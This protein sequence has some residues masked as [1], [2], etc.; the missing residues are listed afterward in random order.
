MWSEST[1]PPDPEDS[2]LNWYRRSPAGSQ[3]WHGSLLVGTYSALEREGT[4]NKI[5]C[6]MKIALVDT[7]TGTPSESL[8]TLLSVHETM[9]AAFHANDAFQKHC[10]APHVVTKIV[11]LREDVIVGELVRSSHLAREGET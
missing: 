4:L 1:N 6:P 9:E 7:R 5:G 11:H 3:D 2:H 10:G 8:G